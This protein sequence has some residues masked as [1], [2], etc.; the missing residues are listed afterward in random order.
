MQNSLGG[1]ISSWLMRMFCFSLYQ[2]GIVCMGVS[3]P[4]F[5]RRKEGSEPFSHIC[6][7]SSA[8]SSKSSLCGSGVFGGGAFCHPSTVSANCII[9]RARG[10]SLTSPSSRR[11]SVNQ[12][13]NICAE[14]DGTKVTTRSVI[15]TSAFAS[16][17][18][19]L[20]NAITEMPCWP[21]KLPCRFL[22]CPVRGVRCP[23]HSAM[24][25]RAG[26]GEQRLQG[27]ISLYQR[28]LELAGPAHV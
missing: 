11:S 8:C 5:G 23:F 18:P 22:L 14:S 3:T 15:H 6:C 7:F 2:R 26:R 9:S 16:R 13:E 24:R 19:S 12:L 25:G 20:K 17:F 4:A 28:P 1:N 27:F 21:I 10:A